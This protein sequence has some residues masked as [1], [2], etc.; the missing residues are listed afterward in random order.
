MII[1]FVILWL[2]VI[3]YK[4]K[5][6]FL[7]NLLKINFVVVKVSKSIFE[8]NI[9][10]SQEIANRDGKDDGDARYQTGHSNSWYVCYMNS[11]K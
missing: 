10:R 4:L 7:Y 11:N 1:S 2:M 8:R 6:S 3:S 9:P 5:K